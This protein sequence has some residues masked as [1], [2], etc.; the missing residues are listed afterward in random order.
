VRPLDRE[1]DP[2]LTWAGSLAIRV[3]TMGRAELESAWNAAEAL[4]HRAVL[5]EHLRA[6]LRQLV[7]AVQER[8]SQLPPKEAAA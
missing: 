1:Y 6:V 5:K 2:A 7:D 8:L 4:Q 3:H